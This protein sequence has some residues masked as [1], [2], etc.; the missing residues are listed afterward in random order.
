MLI[1]LN[2]NY[3][4]DLLLILQQ[5]Q[6]IDKKYEERVYF[7]C[8]EMFPSFSMLEYVQFEFL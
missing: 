5:Q 3:K 4:M 8:E 1:I 7:Q 6:W 2:N